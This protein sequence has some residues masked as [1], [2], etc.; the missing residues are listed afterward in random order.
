MPTPSTSPEVR[1]IGEVIS[2]IDLNVSDIARS[3]RFY[4]DV[5]APLQFRRTDGDHSFIRIANGRDT[6]IVLSAVDTAFR[7]FTYHRKAIGLG[8]FALSMESREWV[9]RMA[10]HVTALRVPILGNGLVD[11]DYRRGYYT[12]AFEDPDRIMVEIVYHDSFYFSLHAP[13]T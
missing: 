13:H 9:D 1:Y 6:V 5:L 10:A 4:L 12:F 8:H 7:H 11:S 2:H 3:A